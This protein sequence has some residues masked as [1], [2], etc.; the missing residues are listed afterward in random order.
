MSQYLIRRI[1][2]SPNITLHTHTE[3]VAL[4]GEEHLERVTWKDQQ[5]GETESHPIRHVFAMT[6]A[7]PNT[8]WLRECVRLDDHLFVKTGADLLPEDLHA[9]GWPLHRP[10]YLFETSVPRVF[11]VGDVRAGSVKRVASAVGEGSVVVQLI[12]RVLSE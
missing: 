8:S 9:A 11:A 5:T 12:H 10:P 3:I 4:E 6:G 1:N 7:N 2:E